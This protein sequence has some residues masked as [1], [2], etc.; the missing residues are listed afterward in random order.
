MFAS[1]A[2][3]YDL[4]NRLHSFGR[5]QAWR[6]ATVGLCHVRPTDDV[7]DA[8]CGTG[9]LTEAFANALPR[10]VTGLDFTP[11][12]LQ[13]AQAK[14]RHERS[15][16]DRPRPR[17]LQG[18]AMALPFDDGAFD[19][20]SIAF[21]I[22]NVIDPL[23]AVCEFRRVLRPGGRLA[24]LEFSRPHNSVIR[25][26]NTL[27]TA[28]VMPFTATLIA[29][30]RS[31]AYHYLPRSVQTFMSAREMTALMTGAGFAAV[32]A[33]PMT[34]GVCTAYLGRVSA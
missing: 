10:S 30:D 22:R 9:D 8:A 28:H 27:Y 20:V 7:L 14:S 15:E 33:H 25:G 24:I 6:R 12:M 17:Y 18:D 11:E 32:T 1:I 34:F 5:D 23:K 19:I 13:I 2:R 29:R 4:N 31:G 3:S 26:F 16:A 21:G